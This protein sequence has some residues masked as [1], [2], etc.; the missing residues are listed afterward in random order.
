MNHPHS[1]E[2]WHT[3]CMVYPPIR[4]L[5][6]LLKRRAPHGNGKSADDDDDGDND[7]GVCT[8]SRKPVA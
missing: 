1:M 2:W 6:M 3:T 8:M 5:K 4:R 7:D